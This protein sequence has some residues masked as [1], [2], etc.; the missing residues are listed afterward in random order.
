[1]KTLRIFIFAAIALFGYQTQAQFQ[2]GATVGIQFPMNDM[3]AFNPGLG[4]NLAGKYMVNDQTSVGLNLGLSRFAT[5]DNDIIG[6]MMPVTLLCEYYLKTDDL[7]PYFG[8]DL[9]FYNYSIKWDY[10]GYHDSSSEF[11]FGFA[12]NVGVLYSLK[13]NMS[14]CA[15]IKFNYVMTDGD[16]ADWLGFNVGVMFDL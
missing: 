4:I 12:P 14:L 16:Y 10:V 5:E 9:G 13:D 11:Y 8:F 7:K 6:T 1:M 15:N 2:V 3:D